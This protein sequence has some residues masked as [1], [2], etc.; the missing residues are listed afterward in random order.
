MKFVNYLVAEETYM[1][2]DLKT[3]KDN[4]TVKSFKEYQFEALRIDPIYKLEEV[5]GD[6]L[7]FGMSETDV[8]DDHWLENTQK[9]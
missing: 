1:Q 2:A 3:S 6:E 9:G 8:N 4:L 7:F 5:I